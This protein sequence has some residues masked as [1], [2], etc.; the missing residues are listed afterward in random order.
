M[1]TVVQTSLQNT[2]PLVE[3]CFFER[4]SDERV[5]KVRKEYMLIVRIYH[6]KIVINYIWAE[7]P[8][9]C[10]ILFTVN[11]CKLWLT[12]LFT[13]LSTSNHRTGII[14]VV[15]PCLCFNVIPTKRLHH[16][17]MI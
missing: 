7:N 3:F 13:F 15:Y 10:L 11:V 17:A 1:G 4:P 14:S 2:K 9:V 8:C 12:S 16:L 6:L 5:C